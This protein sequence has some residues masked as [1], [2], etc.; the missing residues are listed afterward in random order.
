[1]SPYH[2]AGWTGSLV[3][4]S[5]SFRQVGVPSCSGRWVSP[6]APSL[7]VRGKS[8]RLLG[9]LK[10]LGGVVSCQELKEMSI[11]VAKVHAT[12]AVPVVDLAV[13]RR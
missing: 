13:F 9:A 1:M 12:A 2:L 7:S 10:L 11:G 6:R 5:R 4:S 3:R 8:N